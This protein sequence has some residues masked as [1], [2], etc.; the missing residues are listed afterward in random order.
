MFS[1]KMSDPS[2]VMHELAQDVISLK[3]RHSGCPV[4][5]LP[6]LSPAG[7]E[8]Y[9]DK[10]PHK[11]PMVQIRHGPDSD[12]DSE[13][14]WLREW[15]SRVEVSPDIWNA[16]AIALCV[17]CATEGFILWG[18][19]GDIAERVYWKLWVKRKVEEFGKWADD[20]TTTDDFLD[21]C[22]AK[23]LSG[24][25]FYSRHG[26]TVAFAVFDGYLKAMPSESPIFA[27]LRSPDLS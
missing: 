14:A 6:I 18:A 12:Y 4:E 5:L 13:W 1:F 19:S 10:S 11:K 9:R 25:K 3:F 23:L 15:R 27:A 8:Y 24:K 21:N 17:Q 22:K 2:G 16:A 7:I 20:A 26:D